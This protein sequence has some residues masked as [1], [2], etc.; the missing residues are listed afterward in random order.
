MSS[1]GLLSVVVSLGLGSSSSLLDSW[2]LADL[3]PIRWS[4]QLCSPIEY[5]LQ[6]TKVGSPL[7]ELERWCLAC[8][9]GELAAWRSFGGDES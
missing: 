1:L 2:L 5:L 4:R 7:F 3:G 6:L 9:D 8:R